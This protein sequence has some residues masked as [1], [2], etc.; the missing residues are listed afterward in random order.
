MANN[1]DQGATIVPA[2]CLAPGGAEAAAGILLELAEILES[3]ERPK[4]F[5]DFYEG[6]LDIEPQSDGSLYISS[7]DEF[8]CFASFDYLVEKLAER[9]LILK[10]FGIQVAWTCSK[11]RPDEFGGTYHRAYPCGKVLSISTN[12]GSLTDD[13]FEQIYRISTG[14]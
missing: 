13:Q 7:G 9:N 6:C 14:V 8:F 3:D 12:F 4:E 10:S 5:D 1:Y 2:E 11:L